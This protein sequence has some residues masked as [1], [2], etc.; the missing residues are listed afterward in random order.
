M[1][2]VDTVT[3]ENAHKVMLGTKDIRFEYDTESGE[4]YINT[5]AIW[6]APGAL[7]TVE[8]IRNV[9]DKLQAHTTSGKPH[10]GTQ[11]GELLPVKNLTL[12]ELFVY[13]DV[14][15]K[16]VTNNDDIVQ[17][18]SIDGRL[19]LD[20]WHPNQ[21]MPEETSKTWFEKVRVVKA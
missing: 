19:E 9:L 15:Y 18:V 11:D 21:P 17:A 8:E 6:G 12:N 7:T 3:P 13:E 20:F 10:G 14:F 16:I 1:K 2:V 4:L 5:P